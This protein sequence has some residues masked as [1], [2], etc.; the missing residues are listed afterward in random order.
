MSFDQYTCQLAEIESTCALQSRRHRAQPVG[1]NFIYPVDFGHSCASLQMKSEA[2]GW[3][4][5]LRTPHLGPQGVPFILVILLLKAILLN[6]ARYLEK[7]YGTS[8]AA[9]TG[10]LFHFRQA[11][12]SN[13]GWPNQFFC[14]LRF[15]G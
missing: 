13:S 4:R 9:T 12:L 3:D 7:S 14:L 1:A 10:H 8:Y 5:G 2:L 11:T 15:L 6:T